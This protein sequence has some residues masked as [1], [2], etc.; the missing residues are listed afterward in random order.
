LAPGGAGPTCVRIAAV[1][2]ARMPWPATPGIG[3]WLARPWH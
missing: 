1:Q 2:L 3:G